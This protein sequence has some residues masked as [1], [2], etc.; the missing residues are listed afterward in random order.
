[1]KNFLFLFFL[2][3]ITG[4]IGP[5]KE[6]ER[7]IQD[8][9]FDSGLDNT[10]EPLPEDFENKVQVNQPWLKEFDFLPRYAEIVFKE[11]S[12][13]FITEDGVFTKLSQDTGDTLFSKKIDSK[14]KTGLFSDLEDHFYFTDERNFLTKIDK[15]GNLVWSIRLPNSLNLKPFF[16]KNQIIFKYINNNIESFDI[17]TGLSLWSYVRQN[18]PLSINVQSPIIIA[19][20]VLYSGF[21]GGKV[22]IIEPESGS[23]LT[24][25]TL[26]RP[27]GVT[28]IDRTND[29]SGHL[30]IIDNLLVASSY[31][32]EITTFD[33]AS[34]SKIWSRKISSYH[35]VSTDNIN[36][37]VAHENDSIYNF[38]L[39]SG[40][41]IWKNNDLSFR[42]IS[43]PLIYND[44]LLAIDYIGAL[45][46][47]ELNEGERVGIHKSG[48]DLQELI[49]F[50]ETMGIQNSLNTSKMYIHE[51]FV[52]ILL[53]HQKIIKIQVNE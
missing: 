25:L 48:A 45:H 14:I 2:L 24:E 39:K 26:S 35:G 53:N 4:C 27:K 19:D 51:E 17:H 18:P 52:Y 23:F 9:Y 11:D 20:D 44:F 47:I 36:L 31:N 12:I 3:F 33:R 5:V 7:Q 40:K 30:G 16:Y 41:T 6:L 42:K 29:V 46:I 1:M 22:V 34:G 8:V 50:G 37:I 28:E 21:P 13:F 32:G 49:D 43:S 10:P 15:K 38:D